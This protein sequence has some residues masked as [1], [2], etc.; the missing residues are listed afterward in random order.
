MIQTPIALTIA[1]SDSSG[2]AGIQADLRM[3]HAQGVY[4]VSAI[5]AITAQ[6]PHEVTAV[7]G[8][9]PD[10]VRAQLETLLDHLPIRAIKTGMLWSANTVSVVSEILSKH[11]HIPVV[12]DPVM[13]STSGRRLL[14]NDA[15]THLRK[16]L[17]PRC[18]LVTPNL[19]EAG[20]LLQEAPPASADLDE[21]ARRLHH[22]FK[23]PVLLKGGHVTGDPVDTLYDGSK[24][25]RW[26]RSRVHG[27][28][29]H[30]TGCML[31]AA[32]TAGLA[33][34]TSLP[35]AVGAGLHAV[36]AALQSPV[37]LT[38]Y[39]SVSGIAGAS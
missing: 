22:L 29:T 1:G 24:I 19:E 30:G 23:C 18:S 21:T 9:E 13:I 3:F 35:D 4:G 37:R 17:L 27:I 33:K 12:V 26:T 15:V 7:A 20:A 5:T 31:S 6:N 34:G 39:L 2:G 28:N 11:P 32:V 25:T 38:D 8:I 16:Q 14:N 36:Y 10:M